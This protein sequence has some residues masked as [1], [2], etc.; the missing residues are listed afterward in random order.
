MSRTGRMGERERERE[1]VRARVCVPMSLFTIAI[2]KQ[3]S[4]VHSESLAVKERKDQ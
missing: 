3:F 2:C 1:R 4:P